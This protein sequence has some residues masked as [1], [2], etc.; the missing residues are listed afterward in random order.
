MILSNRGEV[1]MTDDDDDA[2]A[3]NGGD[4]D[5]GD[6]DDDGDDDAD[7][8]GGDEDDD[9]GNCIRRSIG[10]VASWRKVLTAETVTL[11]VFSHSSSFK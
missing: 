11:K 3:D 7:A 5:A 10:P 9:D 8:N 4:A 6:G 1:W 2:H